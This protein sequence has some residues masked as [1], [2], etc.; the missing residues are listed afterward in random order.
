M[1]A[2]THVLAALPAGAVDLHA[3]WEQRCNDCHG[4]AGAF[5][6]QFLREENGRLAGRHHRDDLKQFLGQHEMGPEHVEG[7]YGV[8]LAQ[9]STPPLF[10][11]KC[12]RC[13]QTAA[14]FARISLVVKDGVLFGRENQR[15]LTEFLKTH[16]KLSP[17]EVTAIIQTLSRV[18][19]EVGGGK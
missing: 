7:V 15:P 8:L 19:S 13:H 6:R 11:Q 4:H 12:S 14:E 5:A 18:L 3:F 17:E 2:V 10:Q 9:A 1:L 16:G